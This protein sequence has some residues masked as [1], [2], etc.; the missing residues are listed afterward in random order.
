[1]AERLLASVT[2]PI[3]IDEHEIHASM[4]MGIALGHNGYQRVE[5]VP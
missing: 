4:S 1:M 5:D 2:A 3:L